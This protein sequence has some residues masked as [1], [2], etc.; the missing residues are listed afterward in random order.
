M[1]LGICLAFIGIAFAELRLGA[2]TTLLAG[3][4][5]TVVATVAC[6]VVLLGAAWMGSQAA[7]VA[8]DAPD[9]GAS[10][11]T[12]GAVGAAAV[13]FGWWGRVALAVIALNGLVLHHTLADWEH[14][15][16]FGVGTLCGA[17]A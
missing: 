7:R 4:A 13:T 1:T 3:A 9:F 2:R 17:L 11:V 15:V 16:A 6:D 14:L 10:A 12:V 8:A 5:G